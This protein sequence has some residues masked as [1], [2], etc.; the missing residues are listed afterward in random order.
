MNILICNFSVRKSIKNFKLIFY[1]LSF[2]N[3]FLKKFFFSRTDFT[4]LYTLL[5]SIII[6]LSITLL[7][8]LLYDTNEKY[9]CLRIELFFF[10]FIC[11]ITL[12]TQYSSIISKIL[13]LTFFLNL[14]NKEMMYI[15]RI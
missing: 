8:K 13:N 6:L 14:R 9:F 2:K 12:Y 10:Y 4:Q 11:T 3:Y 7:L 1:L 15:S 5:Y